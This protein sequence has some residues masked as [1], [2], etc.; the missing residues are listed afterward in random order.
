[1][2]FQAFPFDVQ[3]CHFRMASTMPVDKILLLADVYFDI[4]EHNLKQFKT[5][6]SPFQENATHVYSGNQEIYSVVGYKLKLKRVFE[7][8]LLSYYSLTLGMVA[9]CSGSFFINPEAIPGRVTM[10]VTIH[11]TMASLFTKVLVK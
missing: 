2:N 10:L 11:L 6:V 7:P 8:Y 4:L 9:I 1:M 3:H 5:S